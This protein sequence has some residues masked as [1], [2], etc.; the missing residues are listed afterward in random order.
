MEHVGMTYTASRG[1]LCAGSWT[2]A[3]PVALLKL[4]ATTALFIQIK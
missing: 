2:L 1:N 3:G 4:L